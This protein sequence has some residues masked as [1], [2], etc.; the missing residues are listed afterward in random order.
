MPIETKNSG[1]KSIP[2]AECQTSLGTAGFGLATDVQIEEHWLELAGG[3]MRYL[4]A[5][6]ARRSSSFMG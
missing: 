2:A 4:K 6:S 3:N 5:G 1:N